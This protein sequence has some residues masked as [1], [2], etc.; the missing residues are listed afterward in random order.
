M[1]FYLKKTL[2]CTDDVTYHTT[3]PVQW[4]CLFKNKSLYG[5]RFI[6]QSSSLQD[7]ARPLLQCTILTTLHHQFSTA[8]YCTHYTAPPL[9]HCTATTPLLCTHYTARPLLHG[10]VLSTL[11]YSLHCTHH[12]T[13]LHH[14]FSTALYSLHFTV[15]TTLHCTHCTVL[16]SL[17]CTTT[18]T[19]PC[20][21]YTALHCAHYTAPWTTHL[22][23]CSDSHL[24]KEPKILWRYINERVFWII[25]TLNDFELIYNVQIW[26]CSFLNIHNLQKQT[27]SQ[28]A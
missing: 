3:S 28:N 12:Y 20:T 24:I 25:L 17:H 22:T 13:T 27:N 2:H 9:L 15:L 26:I 5:I 23:V 7:T 6:I 18:T 21:H 19:L 14:H 10:S 11:H 16:Y 4:N 8:L 1:I